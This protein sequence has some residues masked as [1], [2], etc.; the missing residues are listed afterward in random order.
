HPVG[1][2]VRFMQRLHGAEPAARD[3][4]IGELGLLPLLDQ[5]VGTLSRGQRKRVLLALALVTPYRLLLLDEPF[6][7]LDVRQVRET[8]ALF[9][10]EV[11]RGRT[12][13]LSIHQL[14]DAERVC[15]RMVLLCAGR[16]LGQGT[17]AE[18]R[19]QAGLPQGTLE[20]VFLALT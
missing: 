17:L 1:W 14:G 9:R 18:L 2:A 4:V 15:A 16:V 13:F 10:A 5:P 8:A 12:L 19:A 11:A 20:E 6:E 3:A 7:G